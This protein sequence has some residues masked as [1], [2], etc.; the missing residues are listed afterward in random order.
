MRSDKIL[1]KVVVDVTKKNPKF[2]H[3]TFSKLVEE[4]PIVES[5]SLDIEAVDKF[6]AVKEHSHTHVKFQKKSGMIIRETTVTYKAVRPIGSD[7]YK[8]L[9]SIFGKPVEDSST[10]AR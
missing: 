1:L 10:L 4:A 2:R 9:R 6:H 8:K 5:I 7:V 3:V